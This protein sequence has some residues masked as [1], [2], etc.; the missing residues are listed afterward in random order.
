MGPECVVLIGDRETKLL[1]GQAAGVGSF[2]YDGGDLFEF[3]SRVISA[4]F[5]LGAVDS[6]GATSQASRS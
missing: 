1:A 2:R 4:D 3:T 5:G 6:A